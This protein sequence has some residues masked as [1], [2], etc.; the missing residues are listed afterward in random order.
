MLSGNFE[1]LNKRKQALEK[2]LYM[3]VRDEATK[4]L[5]TINGEAE[6]VA[7]K[8]TVTM[9][10][11]DKFTKRA[12]DI[13]KYMKKN[14]PTAWQIAI[15][16]KNNTKSVLDGIRRFTRRNL[17]KPQYLLIEGKDKA[18]RVI[19]SVSNYAR[20]SLSKGYNFSV[21]AIDIASKTVSRI[22][23]H[24]G[25]ALPRYRDFSIR[26]FDRA[27]S[28]VG[29]VKRTLLSIPSLITV[30]LA[31][32]G[33]NN[34]KDSTVGAAMQFEGYEVAMDHWLNGNKK[35]SQE[36]ITW[37][38]RLADKTPFSSP[39]LFPALTRGIGIADGDV[40]EAKKLLTTAAD[41]AALTPGSS[42]VDAME[43]LADGQMGE[44]ERMK[45]F[46]MKFSEKELEIVG[47][48]HILNEISEKFDGGSEKLSA[49]SQGIIST[50]QGYGSSIMRSFGTGFLD[51][52]KPRLNAISKWLDNNQDK[53]QSWKSTVKKVGTD[54]SEWVFSKLEKG[55]SHIQSNYLENPAFKKLDF[56]GK[57]KFIMDDLGKWWDKTGQPF[58]V[59]VSKDVGSAIFDGIVWGVKEGIKGI[60]GLWGE[61]FKDPS[62]GNFGAAALGTALAGSIAS[63]ILSPFTKGIGHLYKSGKWFWGKGKKVAGMFNKNKGP[64]SPSSPMTGGRTPATQKVAKNTGKP[65][66]TQPWFNKGQM[67]KTPNANS[68]KNA[69]KLSKVLKPLGGLAKRIPYLGTAVGAMSLASAS[70]KDRPGAV[71][72][73]AGGAAGA[74]TGAAIGSIIPG[75]GTL[76]GGAIGG[77]AGSFGGE[78]LGGWL[79]DNW[80]KI[81][82]K[83]SDA[84]TWILD[85]FSGVKDSLSETVFSGSWWGEKWDGVKGWTSE[86]LSDTS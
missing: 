9:E 16:A 82:Q 69:S 85:T 51:P 30:T 54:A 7:K 11:N 41:M 79:G 5:R 75:V 44:F 53:W 86:K 83:A 21:R 26:A 55:F 34:L 65:V 70:K 71:G 22:A 17:A 59:Q 23:S 42:V 73:L 47:W 72:S 76:I 45:A 68:F 74:A 38:G 61:A 49:T 66:Y 52:M 18:T 10:M 80:E 43:A 67:V 77:I 13:N 6:K 1:G 19:H 39:D 40:K 12:A 60:G 37:M 31:V 46:N 57:I 20:R 81:K 56:E 78:A 35:K 29:S 33:L 62:V 4:K 84:G 15:E 25:S 32:V 64:N 3:K 14:L 8:R 48:D 50:L 24:A 2:P 58:M 27:T 63:L 36:L 28:V